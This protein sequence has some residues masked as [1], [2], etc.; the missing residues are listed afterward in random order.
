MREAIDS[1]EQQGRIVEIAGTKQRLKAIAGAYC[2]NAEN[3]LVVS[4]RNRERV[5]LNTLIHRQLQRDG[6]VSRDDY[7]M[8]VYMNRQDMTGTER[9][10]ANAYMPGEDIIRYNRA[11]KVYDVKVG[12]YALVT[13]KNHEENEVTVHFENGRELTY[14]PQRLS[15]VSVYREA[16]REFAEGD[17]I[18]FRAPFTEKRIANGEFATIVKI[19]DESMT[20]M[21]DGGR[22]VSFE[23]E[24]FR[25]LDH[26]YALTSH[27]SQGT[28]VDRV[29]INADTSES[30]VLL[31]DRMGYVAVSRARED[32]TIYT[33]S[34]EELRG[35]LD[36]RV[37]KEMAVE[38]TKNSD[39]YARQLRKESTVDPFLHHEQPGAERGLEQDTIE[40]DRE[41]A[42]AANDVAQTEEMEFTLA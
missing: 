5:Q 1:L 18:Q 32:A 2:E 38:A 35:A 8:T 39:D 9:T 28:T 36:R 6:K 21:L 17:R 31:N 23:A 42:D 40:I 15:G 11:S 7:Q 27:S 13:A 25:H 19:G 30:R 41:Q 34:I 10:F 16:K 20:V 26:G 33:N 12:D 14:N 37:D 22:E 3:T 29:L 4:P 24:K